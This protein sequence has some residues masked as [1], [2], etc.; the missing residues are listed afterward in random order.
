MITNKVATFLYRFSLAVL[1][2]SGFAQMP[3]FKRYYIADIPGFGWLA[4]FYTTHMLHYISASVFLFFVSYLV[5]LNIHS[6]KR[7]NAEVIIKSGL[8][9]GLIISG[10]LLVLRNFSGYLFPELFISV[11]NVVHLGLVFMLLIFLALVTLYHS[12]KK[13][14]EM[15]THE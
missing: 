14:E 1:V 11:V 10:F 2:V 4:H 13:R 7:L 15:V 9:S 3:V 8:F 12:L 5:V 6:E